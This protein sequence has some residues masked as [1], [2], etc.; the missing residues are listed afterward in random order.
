MCFFA[1]RFC[2]LRG[3]LKLKTVLSEDY[4]MQNLSLEKTTGCLGYI[5]SYTNYL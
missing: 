5:G 2:R 3:F 1:A 4:L